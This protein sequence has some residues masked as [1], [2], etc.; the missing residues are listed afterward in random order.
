[1]R[2]AEQVELPP[3]TSVLE[4]DPETFRTH[5][6]RAAF[7]FRHRWPSHPMLSL[8][9]LLTLAKRLPP[10]DVHQHRAEVRIDE[11]FYNAAREHPAEC[12]LEEALQDIEASNSY[13]MLRNPHGDPEY[14]EFLR[15]L[16][17]EIGQLVDPIDPGRCDHMSSFL[18]RRR[19]R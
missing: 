14:A 7:G 8:R 9:S 4:F 1:M 11:D 3:P 13:I 12:T 15:P 19:G 17:E 16:W 5:Y 18:C 10:A 6:N 2:Q